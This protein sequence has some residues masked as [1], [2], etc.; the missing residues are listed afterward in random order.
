MQT[1]RCILL[2]I[3]SKISR[4]MT[5]TEL[6]RRRRSIFPKSYKPAGG[7]IPDDILTDILENANHAP[8]H[9]MTEPWRFKIL[10]GGAKQRLADFLLNDFIT[11][12]PLEEQTEMKIKKIQENPVRS[13]C[14]IV[15][16][17]KKHPDVVPEWEEIAAVSMAVQNMWLT[18]TAH[19]IGAYWSSPSAIT[20]RGQAFL[21]LADDERCLGLFYMGYHNMPDIP[22]QRQP[23]ADKIEFWNE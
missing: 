3:F 13:A 1:L 2:L 10:R 7:D 17:M 22:T 11:N 6:I 18:C 9:R 16:C 4:I 19:N 8:N 5:I 23:I 21:N 12:A 14:I 20:N 15:I